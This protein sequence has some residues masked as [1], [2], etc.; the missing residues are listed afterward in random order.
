[1]HGGTHGLSKFILLEIEVYDT[2]IIPCTTTHP[3]DQKP[4]SS[5]PIRVQVLLYDVQT[6]EVSR[7]ISRFKDCAYS[8]CFRSD[9]KLLVAGSQDGMVQVRKDGEESQGY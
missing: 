4:M 8:G 9:G 2:L 3:S 5:R 7:T 6:K 1:M